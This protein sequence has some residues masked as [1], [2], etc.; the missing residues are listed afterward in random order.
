[1]TLQL[2]V[3]NA[4][5]AARSVFSLATQSV[6]LTASNVAVAESGV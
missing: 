6:E 1:M 4:K 5:T 2:F 3:S